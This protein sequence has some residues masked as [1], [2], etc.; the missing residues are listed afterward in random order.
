LRQPSPSSHSE[1]ESEPEIDA[2]EEILG[3]DAS[4]DSDVSEVEL[5]EALKRYLE[6]RWSTSIPG[7]VMRYA[8]LIGSV[9]EL[10]TEEAGIPG[11]P[12]KKIADANILSF[13]DTDRFVFKYIPLHDPT[14][15][16]EKGVRSAARRIQQ[17]E[18]QNTRFEFYPAAV[19]G[20]PSSWDEV[21]NSE[22]EE[23]D[24]VDKH[25]I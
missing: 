23:R 15:M 6:K 11:I 3:M 16:T 21:E 7:T 14:I 19:I 10:W 9:G 22:D 18:R 24:A 5:K 8:N 13:F 25:I 2:A 1:S 17:W 12:W 4:A 20:H